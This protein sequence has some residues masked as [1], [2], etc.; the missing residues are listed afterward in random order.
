MKNDPKPNLSPAAIQ[1]NIEYYQNL[2]DR[3]QLSH[4]EY[5]RS[6]DIWLK[7]LQK[8]DKIGAEN[9]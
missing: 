5:L 2:A 9:T 4:I 1:A 8:C 3:A 7:M 6:R